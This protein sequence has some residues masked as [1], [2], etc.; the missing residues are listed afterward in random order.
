MKATDS[1]KAAASITVD[2]NAM[3][4]NVFRQNIVL[5][6]PKLNSAAEEDS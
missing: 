1:V 6:K 3:L 4:E 2:E 5:Q